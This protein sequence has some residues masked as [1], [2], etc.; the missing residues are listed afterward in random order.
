MLGCLE[1][2]VALL[3]TR[4]EKSDIDTAL[5]SLI[6]FL[7]DLQRSYALLPAQQD[8]DSVRQGIGQLANIMEAAQENPVIAAAVGSRRPSPAQQK[9][10]NTVPPEEAR[11]LLAK[12]QPM[13][14]DAI[15]S[16]LEAESY[17]VA[18]L[19]AIARELGIKGSKLKRES[20]IHQIAAKIANL[21][22]YRMLMG[23]TEQSKPDPGPAEPATAV[24]T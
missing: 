4:E 10:A 1:Q 13:S 6:T 21:R 14:F 23:E 12:L 9:T 17:S 11:Q 19:R 20:L 24:G 3:P 18:C 8:L 5:N 15:R 16:E 7:G 2:V 22:G